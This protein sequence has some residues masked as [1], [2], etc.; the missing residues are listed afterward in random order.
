MGLLLIVV[1]LGIAYGPGVWRRWQVLRLQEACMTAE[2]PADRR[3]SERDSAA[4]GALIAVWPGKYQLA[5]AG[6]VVRVAFRWVALA[7]ELGLPAGRPFRAGTCTRRY[8]VK[9]DIRRTGGG[10]WSLPR[11][12]PE[13]R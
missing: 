8:S 1:G 3:V 9:S 10:G 12:W 4:A 5:P 2:M 6:R 7:G 13:S 11:G